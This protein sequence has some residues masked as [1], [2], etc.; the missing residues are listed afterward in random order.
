MMRIV[1]TAQSPCKIRPPPLH[2]TYFRLVK[3]RRE[4]IA[5]RQSTLLV[6]NNSRCHL[7]R[8]SES[9]HDRLSGRRGISWNFSHGL[10]VP[11]G[12]QHATHRIQTVVAAAAAATTTTVAVGI[13]ASSR[14]PRTPRRRLNQA[15]S[16]SIRESE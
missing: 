11:T 16:M 3:C 7:Q 1:V 13:P 2:R 9:R 5:I 14:D 15:N 8:L 4:G 6:S 10:N 12:F